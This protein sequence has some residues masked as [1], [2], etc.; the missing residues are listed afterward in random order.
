MSRRPLRRREAGFTL[1]ETMIAG[2]V[3]F[4]ALFG[5]GLLANAAAYNNRQAMVGV[6]AGRLA[7]KYLTQYS[8]L[9]VNGPAS[10]GLLA[11]M[12]NST[13]PSLSPPSPT[14][15][16]W[17]TLFPNTGTLPFSQPQDCP[18]PYVAGQNTATCQDL[19]GRQFNL[20]V[21]AQNVTS[22]YGAGTTTCIDVRV[23]VS[24]NTV[25]YSWG[26]GTSEVVDE[27]IVSQ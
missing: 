19:N 24:W 16:N 21:E 23:T 2:F 11:A 27:A 8:I 17:V 7:T 13:N 15:G 22:V 18:P 4:I 5:I 10:N 12:A 9:G 1:L 3:L 14:L 6:E 25:K 20:T 26:W